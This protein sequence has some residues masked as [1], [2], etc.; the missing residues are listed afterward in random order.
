MK[1]SKDLPPRIMDYIPILFRLKSYQS[2][3]RGISEISG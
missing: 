3:V 1:L 2:R